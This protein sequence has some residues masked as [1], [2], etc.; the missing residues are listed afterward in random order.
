MHP[1]IADIK[2]S[3]YFSEPARMICVTVRENSVGN[4]GLLSIPPVDMTDDL[5]AGI[6]ITAVD[7]NKAKVVGINLIFDNNGVPALDASPTGRNSISKFT[8]PPKSAY[9][10]TTHVLETSEKC[11]SVLTQRIGD[12]DVAQLAE[13]LRV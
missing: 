8:G 1:N 4:Y 5:F 9:S 2:P 7:N 10:G 12:C 6:Y 11:I 13:R 3:Q